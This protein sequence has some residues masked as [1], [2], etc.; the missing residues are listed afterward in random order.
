MVKPVTGLSIPMSILRLNFITKLIYI[1]LSKH[2][3]FLANLITLQ[4]TSWIT[5]YTYSGADLEK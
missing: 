2:M 3:I 5:V 1:H 4:T